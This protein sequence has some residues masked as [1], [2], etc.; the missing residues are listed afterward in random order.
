MQTKSGF[1][2]KRLSLWL[3]VICY[4]AF[5][6]MGCRAGKNIPYFKNIPDS[7]S[8]PVVVKHTEFVEPTI[9]SNDILLIQV[10]TIDPRSVDMINGSNAVNG[11]GATGSGSSTSASS[12]YLVDKN[13]TI[14]LPLVG[15]V[16][17]GGLTTTEAREVIREKAKQYYKDPI[18]NVKFGNF[19]ITMLGEF[20]RPGT[21]NIPNEKVSLLDALGM[22]GDMTI[23][24]KR[25]N[26]LLLR[27]ENGTKVIYRFN[28]NSTDV[29][30][31]PNFYLKQGD[32]VYAVPNKA[33]SRTSTV[34]VTKD[35]YIQY[36]V[37]LL[38]IFIALSYRF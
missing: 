28:M 34:D 12:G 6:V 8:T 38:T 23:T 33:K 2:I 15:S 26:V 5:S 31:S 7:L 25:E 14:E 36:F 29:L 16:K 9:Q 37:S 11:A 21:Y 24:A 19:T 32:V 3:P 18:V 22:A 4:V 17:V 35:R 20:A 1:S 30:K 27:E 10:Q 13:G